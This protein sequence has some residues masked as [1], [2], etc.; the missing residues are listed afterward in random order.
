V[1]GSVPFLREGGKREKVI[2][3]LFVRKKY[4]MHDSAI[5]G[6]V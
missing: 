6:S 3:Y 2:P 5:E 1:F 4:K